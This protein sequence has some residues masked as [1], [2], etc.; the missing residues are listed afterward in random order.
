VFIT[1]PDQK[2]AEDIARELVES[3]L[4]ACVNI[5][6]GLKSFYEWNGELQSDSEVLLIVK[7][8]QQLFNRVRDKVVSLHCYELPEIIAINLSDGL[9][10]YLDW[11][12]AQTDNQ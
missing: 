1:V 12:V 6:P 10:G 4:A 2:S 8:Q 9:K 11:I 5:I 3:K 7:T